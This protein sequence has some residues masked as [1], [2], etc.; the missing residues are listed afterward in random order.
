MNL[1]IV[2]SHDDQRGSFTRTELTSRQTLPNVLSHGRMPACR[3][4]NE[5]CGLRC[6]LGASRW[7][8]R[9][10]DARQRDATYEGSTC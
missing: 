7:R 6:S 1:D 8:L 5:W 10:R 4:G 9:T 3:F 2:A